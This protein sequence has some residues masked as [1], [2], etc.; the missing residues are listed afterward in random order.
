MKNS[1]SSLLAVAFFS[2][3]SLSA[4]EGFT[5]LFDGKSLQGWTSAHSTGDGDWGPFSVNEEEKAIHVYADA[6]AN[7]EQRSDCLNTNTEFSHF[8]L[9]LEYKWLEDRF[10]PRT[11][12]D[13]D[14]GLLFHVHGDLTQVWPLCLEMQIGES[15]GDKPNARGS[16]GRFHTGDLFVLGKDLR[17]D[18]PVKDGAYDPEAEKKTGKH[19][20]TRLGKEKP[21]GEWNE[22]EI[23]VHGSEKATFILNGEVV[24]ET[25]NFTQKNEAGERVPL[26]KGRIGL[27]AEWAELLYRN[28]RIKEL[29]PE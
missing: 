1:F 10:A 26:E 19:V 13:R 8:I 24:L 2:S 28:I 7:S 11:D 16:A 23:H 27:Q 22:M 3:L 29:Q 17:T 4:E 12:W 14:A 5:P 15:P 18:T 6:A 21:K 9:K 25:F 20:L